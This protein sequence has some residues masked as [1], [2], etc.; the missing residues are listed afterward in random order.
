MFRRSILDAET[1]RMG[2]P[3][4]KLSSSVTLV[5]KFLFPV[6]WIGM[7]SF[8]TFTLYFDPQA[9]SSRGHMQ[10]NPAPFFLIATVLGTL[11]LYWA[12]MRLKVVK[13]EGS[14]LI[15]SNYLRTVRVPL[16]DVESV[17]ASLFMNPELIWITFRQPTDFGSKIVFMPPPR[18]H[19][20]L[21]RHP[22]AAELQALLDKV[23][24]GN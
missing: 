20:G 4:R 14:D 13:L 18:F 17:S 3:V 19:F 12:C 15:I 7:F 5:Y 8:G 1:A 24:R 22:M 10:S 6:F 23:Q 11:F 2:V 21:T 9:W 16:R